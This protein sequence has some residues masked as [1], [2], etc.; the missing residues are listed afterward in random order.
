MSMVSIIEDLSDNFVSFEVKNEKWDALHAMILKE[1]SEKNLSITDFLISSGLNPK[2]TYFKQLCCKT[3]TQLPPSKRKS[4]P[5]REFRD[6]V[7]KYF[8]EQV[9]PISS[10]Q[11]LETTIF[12]WCLDN[13]LQLQ[14]NRIA[15]IRLVA[16]DSTDLVVYAYRDC[17]LSNSE[18]ED[19][20]KADAKIASSLA[21]SGSVLRITSRCET[22]LL[23]LASPVCVK[24]E[25]SV[26]TILSKVV[27]CYG[28]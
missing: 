6:A 9:I 28:Q 27:L 5:G 18:I 25:A 24:A 11:S 2:K 1:R 26:E 19:M 23:A 16:P 15:D 13:C 14:D 3:I 7:A 4:S 12:E 17:T 20:L 8:A 10:I 22:Q 21:D